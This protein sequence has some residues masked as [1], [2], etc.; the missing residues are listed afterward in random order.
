MRAGLILVMA[1][2]TA[3]LTGG[4]GGGSNAASDLCPTPTP[5]TTV[6]MQDFEFAPLCLEAGEGATITVKNSGQAPHTY[7]VT[8]INVNVDLGGGGS[9]TVDLAGVAPGTY[10]VVCTYHPQMVGALRVG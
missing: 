4:C 2:A 10:D 7:T 9:E 8:D 6:E 1:I 5:G 3:A